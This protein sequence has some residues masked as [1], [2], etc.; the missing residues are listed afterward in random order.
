VGVIEAQING[1]P[2]LL[3]IGQAAFFSATATQIAQ[4]LTGDQLDDAGFN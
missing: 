3:V 1:Y 2:V 4:P